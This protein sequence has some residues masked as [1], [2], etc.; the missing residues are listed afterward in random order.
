MPEPLRA[1]VV[2]LG[3][4]GTNHARVYAESEG[5]DLVAVADID[6]R[7]LAAF[8]R[9]RT[10][11]PYSDF[12]RLLDAERPDLVSI[13][14]PTRMHLPLALMALERGVATLVEKPLAADVEDGCRLRDAAAQAGV[15]LM[16]G[17]IER[18]NPAVAEL[19]RR[20]AAGD[21]G[22][23]F[24][25]H[26]RRVGPFPQRVRDVGVVH[27]LAPHDIDVMRFVLGAE[28]VRVQAEIQSRISTDQ[29]DMLSGLLRFDNGAVG[30][31]DVNWLTPAKIRE[32]SVLGERGMFVVD[33]L[34]NE[35]RFYE[36]AWREQGQLAWPA[37]AVLT[38]VSEGGM[39][40]PRVDK[41]EP[42][43]VEIEAFVAAVR[44][45]GPSPVPAEDGLAA[46]VV[47]DALV[48]S[49]RS[50]RAVELAPGRPA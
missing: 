8:V 20:V 32:L 16:V 29:E 45:G 7:R 37:L 13:A 19:R 2:G 40:R 9:G 50:G 26:A 35:L 44:T 6:V 39:E 36:N 15:L 25:V 5:V 11:R 23:V 12:G 21:L 47:A 46:M 42:L 28:V 1:A 3:S 41:R 14:V 18:F 17:H 33:Y 27:D 22:R 30:V 43:Q 10:C 31:L 38:G 48:E 24:Q 49:G 34:T 4:M